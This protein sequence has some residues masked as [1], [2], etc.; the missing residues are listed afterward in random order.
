MW[1]CIQQSL[2]D[3]TTKMGI[4]GRASDGGI[5]RDH[6]ALVCGRLEL[7]VP[8]VQLQVLTQSFGPCPMVQNFFVH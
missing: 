2:K 5:I 8:L 3:N 6:N 4:L 1:K 7:A